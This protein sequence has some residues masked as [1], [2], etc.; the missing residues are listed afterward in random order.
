MFLLPVHAVR[1]VADDVF[2]LELER[3]GYPFEPGECAVLFNDAADSRP[4]SMASAP[5]EPVLRFLIRRMPGGAVSDWLSA[6]RPGEGVRI[7]TPF[8]AFRPGLGGPRGDPGVFI[9]TGVGI[10][11]FLS[12]LRSEYARQA[13]RRPVC[14]YG[15]RRL[16]DAVHLDLLRRETDLH[17]ALSREQLPE[18]HHGRVTDLLPAIEMGPDRH[19]YLCGLDAM[20]D[21]C[22]RQLAARGVDHA[23]MHWEVFFSAEGAGAP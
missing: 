11:P 1:S 23:R 20:V 14:L 9:A 6:R 3:R 2:E 4:Y 22:A 21:D 8:G 10:A 19:T 7:S 13:V 18:I 12:Y 17:L 5:H 16:A 15:V